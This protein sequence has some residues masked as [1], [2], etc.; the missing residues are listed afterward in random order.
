MEIQERK[1]RERKE[2]TDYLALEIL[3]R[4]KN[5][6]KSHNFS[7][8][9]VAEK[10]DLSPET[11]KKYEVK[12]KDYEERAK[13]IKGM[14]IE[15]LLRFAKLYNVSIDYLLCQTN[16][17]IP[18]IEYQAAE[19][20]FGLSQETL[21]KLENNKHRTENQPEYK[22]PDVGMLN[23]NLTWEYLYMKELSYELI[24]YNRKN[25]SHR[26][27]NAIDNIVDAIKYDKDFEKSYL[28]PTFTGILLHIAYGQNFN[29]LLNGISLLMQY[30]I[31]VADTKNIRNFVLILGSSK[32]ESTIK[33]IKKY[34]NDI[35]I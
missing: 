32:E 17:S 9:Q 20:K 31:D 14:G 34:Y 11:I 1:Q 23:I 28:M 30:F 19:R 24:R 33:E 21:E 6:R 27:K 2:I 3:E 10:T 4:L 15:N 35:N 22:A 5:L 18:D 8:E 13:H 16:I 25:L 26:I 29:Y 12:G 7:V